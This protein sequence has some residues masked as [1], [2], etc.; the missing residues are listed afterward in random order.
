M[1]PLA[2]LSVAS[3][4]FPFVKTGGLAD[5]VGALPGA[6]AAEGVAVRTLVPGYPGVLAALPVAD[7]ALQLP[8]FFGGDA[9]LIAGRAAGLDVVALDAPHLYARPGNPYLGPDGREWPDNALRFAALAAAAAELARG[10]VPTLAPDIV[11]AHD[12]Q[13]GLT[14]AFLRYGGGKHA[15]TVMTVHN[16]AFQGQYP[17]ELLAELGL[18]PEAFSIEGVEYYGAIGFLKAGLALADRITTVS[19]TYAGEIRTPEGGMGLDGLLR[20]RVAVLSGIL[21]GLDT[22]AWDPSTDPLIPANYDVRTLPRRSAN[23]TALQARFGLD[24]DP[25]AL[26]F[27][28]V[29]R[30]T[31]QKGMDLLHE[32]L[33]ALDRAHAQL[34]VLGA[35]D[36]P[37]EAAF[38][39]AAACRPGRMATMIGYDEPLAHLVQAG[40]D[41][42]LVPSR[43]EPCGLTQLAALRYGS[44]PVAA[45][46]GGLADTVVDA[47]DMAL[48]SSAGT[49]FVFSPVSRE[50]LEIVIDRVAAL[51]RQQVIWRRVQ[52]RA[53]FTDVSW[54]RPARRYAAL[55]RELAGHAHAHAPAHAPAHA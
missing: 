14:P 28:V 15:A 23:K 7:V 35:G 17:H 47:N 1:K 40:A 6:L 53:M 25:A 32:A 24:P 48:A 19:P 39:A 27:G 52:V 3:E 30:L 5:V 4:A 29:S 2:V 9:Q 26:L 46:V 50:T 45:R 43:F 36:R 33:P 44:L 54:T 20:E 21:N 12:W 11:H 18:P 49:G 37:L 34:V 42:L 8:D 13:A 55:Y 22:A 51:W 38:T 41:A 31:W 10:R 16:L